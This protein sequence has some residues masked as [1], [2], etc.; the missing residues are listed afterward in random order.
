MI[1]EVWID[2]AGW[3]G[4]EPQA[5]LLGD[6]LDYILTDADGVPGPARIADAE[7][8]RGP[9]G[10]AEFVDWAFAQYDTDNDGSLDC[11]EAGALFA[12]VGLPLPRQSSSPLSSLL[13]PRSAGSAQVFGMPS[14]AANPIGGGGAAVA[15]LIASCDADEDGRCVVHGL[16]HGLVSGRDTVSSPCQGATMVSRGVGSQDI[17]GRADRRRHLRRPRHPR[18]PRE[19]AEVRAIHMRHAGLPRPDGRPDLAGQEH[20]W[21]LCPA[22]RCHADGAEPCN[23]PVH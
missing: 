11:T 23:Q 14:E 7:H 1:C 12:Q 18:L 9:P 10:T 5:G 21:R 16:V 6:V 20:G 3:I 17:E 22:G 15:E 2:G 19:H 4:I 8:L 13:L